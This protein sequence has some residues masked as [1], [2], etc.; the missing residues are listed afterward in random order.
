MALDP[1][2]MLATG[3]HSQPGVYA[4]LLGSGVSSGAG[5]PTGWGVVTEL[6]RRAAVAA[7]PGDADAADRAAA[8][9]ES[10]W[11]ANGDGQPL[12]YSNLLTCLAPTPAARGA[13]LTTF[14]EPDEADA[15]QG[16]KV[17][18]L[19]HRAI[20]KLVKAGLV[21]VIVTTNFDRLMERALDEAGVPPQVVSR[22]EAVAGLTPLPHARA[23]VVKLHGDYADLQTR[24]TLDEL[25]DYPAEWK[26]L[27]SRVVDE[28]GLV[29]SGWSADWD[30]ALVHALEQVS[31]RRYPLYWDARSSRGPVATRLL[32]QH[33]G[34]VIP[35]PSADGLFGRLLESVE[36]LDRLAEPPLTTA[37]AVARLKRYLPDPVRRI[38]LHDLVTN[39]TDRVVERSQAQPVDDPT[40]TYE[41][42]EQ[43]LAER[44]ED[45]LPLLQLL[46]TGV[47]H[48]TNGS[49]AR[50]WLQT[51]YRLMQARSAP[52]NTYK[53]QLEQARH[54]PALLALRTMGVIAVHSGHDHV[55]AQLL[56]EAK[57]RDWRHSNARIPAAHALHDMSVLSSDT[58]NRLPR[59]AGTQWHYPMSHLV[60]ADLR[61]PL[62]SWI[63]DDDDYQRAFDG[64]EYRAALVVHTTQDVPGALRGAPGEFI[65]HY[66]W[67]DDKPSAETRFV[68]VMDRADDSWHWWPI[69][70]GLD[71]APRTIESLREDLSKMRR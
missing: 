38:D 25:S 24:N 63:P 20:A 67:S 16:L 7:S 28:Y 53:P 14:F 3:M 22:P 59:W 30:V 49:H 43:I 34:Q 56:T 52:S 47:G 27:L 10:W 15:D 40:L 17:P 9:P 8:D 50:L 71:D 18:S 33:R 55:L 32:T 37:M 39:Y 45:T 58:V 6:I 65:F 62:R 36:A 46:V 42:M 66:Q 2:V 35:A 11:A 41:M 60:R 54:Y 29:I 12:G 1:L 57:Y 70:A 4:L 68:E 31:A 21:K 13:L 64:Y 5:I 48:D 51:L 44:R 23:T 61:E 26:T 69:L 19:A